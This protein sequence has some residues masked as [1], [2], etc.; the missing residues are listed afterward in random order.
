MRRWIVIGACFVGLL[1]AILET[2]RQLL[3]VEEP[4]PAPPP[5]P[6]PPPVVN[7]GNALERA[8]REG[9]YFE[10]GERILDA[11]Q[12]AVDG[13]QQKVRDVYDHVQ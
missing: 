8:L 7:Q 2:G 12:D 6:P 5:P 3:F 9:D 10:E 13:S 11:R 1:L 4:P